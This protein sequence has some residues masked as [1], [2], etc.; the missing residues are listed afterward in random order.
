MPGWKRDDDPTR[1][2]KAD[3]KST[4]HLDFDPLP[5]D[6]GGGRGDKFVCPRE[7]CVTE[8]WLLAV[9]DPVPRCKRHDCALV[10]AP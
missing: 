6:G 2:D 1:P 10:R 4:L 8:H 3:P 7:G 5:G 9:G